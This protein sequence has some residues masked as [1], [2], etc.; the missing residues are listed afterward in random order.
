MKKENKRPNKEKLH[1]T[2]NYYDEDTGRVSREAQEILEKRNREHKADLYVKKV[3]K[4]VGYPITVKKASITIIN[5]IMTI[6]LTVCIGIY[7]IL[8]DEIWFEMILI[9]GE[10]AS[11][12]I[13]YFLNKLKKKKLKKYGQKLKNIAIHREKLNDKRAKNI[14][15][16][17]KYQNESAVQDTKEKKVTEKYKKWKECYNSIVYIMTILLLTFS[18]SIVI[19]IYYEAE[20]R[21][22]TVPSEESINESIDLEKEVL[23][24]ESKETDSAVND[25]NEKALNEEADQS[26]QAYDKLKNRYFQNLLTGAVLEESNDFLNDA[27]LVVIN[28]WIK[29]L[30]NKKNEDF[31]WDEQ[32]M[33]IYGWECYKT[34]L[35]DEE[36]LNDI[37]KTDNLYAVCRQYGSDYL[38]AVNTHIEQQITCTER[39]MGAAALR[40]V[41][42]SLIFIRDANV[43]TDG[44]AVGAAYITVA[45]LLRALGDNVYHNQG[46]ESYVYYACA[47]VCYEKAGQYEGRSY[48]EEMNEMRD[49]MECAV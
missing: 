1:N 46:V 12:L 36:E 27:R 14:I 24:E 39:D 38:D 35:Q 15:G 8:Y 42:L 37:E 10:V 5:I 4:K 11:L 22:S 33:D 31:V 2:A 16:H 20:N 17:V 9:L 28:Q 32:E 34:V 49:S 18:T 48:R 29:G 30:G 7:K 41:E 13:L 25:V 19:K 44:H 23:L 3:L 6:I 43:S 45:E 47:Y 26:Q 21:L 40:G